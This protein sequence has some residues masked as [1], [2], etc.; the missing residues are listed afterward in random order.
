MVEV[1]QRAHQWVAML[2]DLMIAALLVVY[3]LGQLG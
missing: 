1:G 3:L 2:T